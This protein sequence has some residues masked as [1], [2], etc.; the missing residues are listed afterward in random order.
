MGFKRILTDSDRQ[1][2]TKDKQ[3]KSVLKSAVDKIAT[4]C[5]LTNDEKKALKHKLTKE[6]T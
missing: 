4:T 2:K 5:S 1:A 6:E 3:N